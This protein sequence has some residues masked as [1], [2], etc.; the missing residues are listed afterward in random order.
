VAENRED[1]VLRFRE[2]SQDIRKA[3]QGLIGRLK[4]VE[5]G[6]GSAERKAKTA[7]EKMTA[8]LTAAGKKIERAFGSMA[9]KVGALLG[10][11][12]ILYSLKRAVDG[13]KEF[14]ASLAEVSTLIGGD[15]TA[16]I[17]AYRG[18]LMQLSRETGRSAT[19]LTSGLYQVV[20]AG[21]KGTESVKGSMKLLDVATKA[22]VAGI[23]DTFSAVDLLTTSL[24]AYGRS[25]DD[26]ADFSDILFT[27]VKMGKTNFNQLA[28]GMGMV[29]STAA[30]AGVKFDELN[31]AYAEL[32]KAGM[33]P[34]RAFTGL[35][36]VMRTLTQPTK[37]LTQ[38][39]YS[40]THMTIEQAVR[41]KGLIGVMEILNRKT[42]GNA[43][44]LKKYVKE[45]EAANAI[46]ILA[47][48]GLEEFGKIMGEMEKRTGAA[49]EAYK[50]MADSFQ[51]Q[52]RR[53][54]NQV[55]LVFI[56]IGTKVLPVL[57]NYFQSMST[58][59]DK[60]SGKIVSFFK[61]AIDA[62]VSLVKYVVEWGPKVVA[63]LAIVWATSGIV[64][65]V[66]WVNKAELAM[67]AFAI[68]RYVL[69]APTI[70]GKITNAWYVLQTAM[71]ANPFV[72]VIAAIAG[73]IAAISQL[74]KY[75]DELKSVIYE[76]PLMRATEKQLH[77]VMMKVRP[78]DREKY[79]AMVES[80]FAK[81]NKAAAIRIAGRLRRMLEL[82]TVKMEVEL[83]GTNGP[84]AALYK[85]VMGSGRYKGPAE[86]GPAGKEKETGPSKPKPD[87]A[88]IKAR[89]K[90]V[91]ILQQY[92][93]AAMSELERG[94]EQYAKKAQAIARMQHVDATEKAEALRALQEV[95]LKQKEAIEKRIEDKKA[96]V[97][98]AYLK[99]EQE[100]AKAR[101]YLFKKADEV[102]E[103]AGD[104]Y[105]K[106][107]L[108]AKATAD[109]VR[110]HV[111]EAERTVREEQA[112]F[113]E[114][115]ISDSL[116]KAFDTIGGK[117][118]DSISSAS[119]EIKGVLGKVFSGALSS[120]WEGLK[121]IGKAFMSMFEGLYQ[122]LYDQ[123]RELVSDAIDAAAEGEKKL[124]LTAADRATYEQQ[125]GR[126]LTPE[127][128][129]NR[130]SAMTTTEIATA[131]RQGTLGDYSIVGTMT[132]A[133]R[134]QA[135]LD[136]M[137]SWWENLAGNLDGIL[138]W[139]DKAAQQL[140]G[141]VIKNIPKI[142]KAL[143]DSWRE[144][145]PTVIDMVVD[146]VLAIVDQIPDLVRALV[147][148]ILAA[149]EKLV[150]RIP[151]L[152]HGIFTMV[153]SLVDTILDLVIDGI[154]KFTQ[155]LVKET[156]AI[157]EAIVKGLFTELLPGLMEAIVNAIITGIKN[158]LNEGPFKAKS[159]W[160]GKLAKA[161]NVGATVLSGGISQWFHEG[162][163]IKALRA[164]DGMV[165]Q[166]ALRGDEVPIVA[167]VGERMLSRDEYGK[168]G[169]ETGVQQAISEGRGGS[170]NNIYVSPEYMIGS[171]IAEVLDAVVGAGLRQGTG[172]VSRQIR[173]GSV[174]GYKVKRG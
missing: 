95:W 155:T 173:R 56:K 84:V 141:A 32:T 53:F 130:A 122:K 38:L 61:G 14:Q 137:I 81:Y 91:N 108:D 116:G 47:G 24:N 106:M 59:L 17:N 156:P 133:D 46:N 113:V 48:T 115:W 31:A 6:L 92:K 163:L 149:V 170:V 82:E 36:A 41:T 107:R 67:K 19:E 120:V 18:E 66:S 96:A 174:P 87:D 124:V 147:E 89:K 99:K 71:L 34:A 138:K 114:E 131:R 167:Q 144:S 119:P 77:Q 10:V 8:S 45:Q 158:A 75:W 16:K 69:D 64:A 127:E 134:M 78:E 153:G 80:S 159:G 169:G 54:W 103:K 85:W 102:A 5:T 3:L 7:A 35:Q 100:A 172:E 150:A 55:E 90:E 168:M 42:Q 79:I 65:F 157:I 146:L 21:T 28:M 129:R 135:V 30:N 160:K 86:K 70:I 51:E 22:A 4:E 110:G 164:H 145:L 112:R 39:V 57:M 43:F 171:S 58:W 52:S 74:I 12:G 50:K 93:L 101:V 117:I 15:A 128:A 148:G 94:Y 152:I 97:Q 9:V 109:A 111:L 105:H 2:E 166:H 136:K 40:Q 140:V 121:S 26:A 165:I 20:S 72:A 29:A 88:W 33:L 27:S 161:G 44:S 73:F 125:M 151:D 126:A 37:E 68:S 142:F 25:A 143:N 104:E 139:L 60:N 13:A 49:G 83:E 11:G 63:I 62:I 123:L 76:N 132:P 118:A 23:S 154:P 162:G 1:M 98:D